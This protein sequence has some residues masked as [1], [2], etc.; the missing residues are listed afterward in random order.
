MNINRGYE[1]ILLR[2]CTTGMES[3]YTQASLSQTTGAILFF[4]MS[5]QYSINSDELIAGLPALG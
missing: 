5:G 2:D 3:K 4:E 1:T